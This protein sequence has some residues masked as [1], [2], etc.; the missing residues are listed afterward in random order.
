[1]PP[2]PL[3]LSFSFLLSP[4]RKSCR[5]FKKLC[6]EDNS[7]SWELLIKV[8]WRLAC[9][10]RGGV[11][12]RG[13][14][15]DVDGHFSLEVSVYNSSLPWMNRKMGYVW[16]MGRWGRCLWGGKPRSWQEVGV[17]GLIPEGMLSWPV[18]QG[19]PSI[20]VHAVST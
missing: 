15:Q 7:L 10:G 2:A 9:G 17:S 13:T 1:M 4:L 5:K 16:S 6:D 8:E 18:E 14:G 12:G 19:L 3:F 11:W 20:L